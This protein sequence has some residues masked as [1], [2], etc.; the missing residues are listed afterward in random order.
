MEGIIQFPDERAQKKK[1]FYLLAALSSLICL[2]LIFA[3]GIYDV[4][5]GP[6]P[7][8]L[9][10]LIVWFISFIEVRAGLGLLILTIA[11][12]P[13]FTLWG[14]PNIRLEDFLL[15]AVLMSWLART[16]YTR[17]K[18]IPS[19]LTLPIVLLVLISL[20][21]SLHNY[22]YKDLPF[23]TSLFRL[24]KSVEYYIMFYLALNI[25]RSRKEISAYIYMLCIAAGL[26]TLYSLVK[27]QI[28]LGAGERIHGLPGE[29]ANIYGGFLIFHI[30]ILLGITSLHEKTRLV[31]LFLATLMAIPFVHTLSRSSYVSLFVGLVILSLLTKDR[32]IM[33]FLIISLALVLFTQARDR[34]E[35]IF[36]IISGHPPSSWAA[37]IAGWEMFLP[38]IVRAP[39]FGW[40]LGSST[41][42]IDNEYVR[43]IYELGILGF[44]VFVWLI[45][46]A[47]QAA[48]HIFRHNDNKLFRGFAMGYL[49]GL[50]ALLVH[51]I[52]ATSFTAIR[53]TEPFFIATGLI[54]AIMHKM[55]ALSKTEDIPRT[56]K[57]MRFRRCL[58]GPASATSASD[59]I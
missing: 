25:A 18:L 17:D 15:P 47:G 40:G 20:V 3:E 22:I 38:K 30:C 27:L 10:G 37:R 57:P 53:T 33:F 13:E 5:F 23:L 39:V 36:G 43:Q 2:F 59:Q 32:H 29:T 8:I 41:L 26:A 49:G 45:V 9:F 35:T 7:M 6:I 14:V 21:S 1:P 58:N 50:A 24:G 34:F 28:G 31:G 56:L 11:V 4:S 44:V 52:A 16:L 12:S 54:C 55:P 46:R 19:R 51:G 42:A 48:L